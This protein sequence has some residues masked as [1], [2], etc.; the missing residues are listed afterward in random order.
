VP[1]EGTDRVETESQVG[2]GFQRPLTAQEAVL[3][4]L[5][6]A[7]ITGDL[8]PGSPIRQDALAKRFGVSR[9]P[10]REALKIL[11][12]EGQVLYRPHKGYLVAKLDH[13]E[14]RELYHIRRLLEEEA[15]RLAI[16]NFTDE[17]LDEL[18]GLAKQMS[19]LEPEDIERLAALNRDFHFG[20]FRPCG[21]PRLVKQIRLLWDSSDAYRALYYMDGKQHALVHE[22]HEAL[23]EAARARQTERVLE[24]LEAHRQNALVHVGAVLEKIN[25]N[26]ERAHTSSPQGA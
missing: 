4:Q 21:L 15:I 3:E 16:P 9:V 17:Q 23:V 22:E 5:R 1:G 8:S 25:G 13:E 18:E 12:G 24:V 6:R 20:F 19:E 10:V 26:A 14:V 11:E 2:D 7:I